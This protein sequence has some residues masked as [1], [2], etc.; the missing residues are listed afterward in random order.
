ENANVRVNR[1]LPVDPRVNV[2]GPKPGPVCARPL[3]PN[4][5]KVKMHSPQS[6]YKTT[7]DHLFRRRAEPG[8]TSARVET[9]AHLDPQDFGC[10]PMRQVRL[11]SRNTPSYLQK[12]QWP[13][14]SR[15]DGAT[16]RVWNSRP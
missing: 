7:V 2:S 5:P 1:S 8:A 3:S 13:A 6:I 4:E 16:R 9:I 12:W 15:R 10:R 11:G 14:S